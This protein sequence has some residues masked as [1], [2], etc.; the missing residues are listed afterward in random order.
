MKK[1]IVIAIIL[2]AL[3]GVSVYAET[4]DWKKGA[5]VVVDDNSNYVDYWWNGGFPTV[6]YIYYE[7][8]VEDTDPNGDL[9]IK[10]GE[11]QIKS[12]ILIIK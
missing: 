4:F 1:L 9:H 6:V 5:P 11:M 3:F 12:N 8:V 2:S 10:D 7:E